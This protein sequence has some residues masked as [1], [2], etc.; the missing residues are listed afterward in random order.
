MDIKLK[1]QINITIN[2]VIYKISIFNG[3][4]ISRGINN[5]LFLEI[6]TY[7]IV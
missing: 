7:N 3:G 4:D 2:D 1:L 5:V 6:K